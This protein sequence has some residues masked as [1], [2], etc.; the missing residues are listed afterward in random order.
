M[1]ACVACLRKKLMRRFQQG[2]Y[3]RLPARLLHLAV[4]EAEALA[5]TTPEP[6]LFF[7]AL[8]EEKVESLF[9]WAQRQSRFM[10]NKVWPANVSEKPHRGAKGPFESVQ[11]LGPVPFP[12]NLGR[13]C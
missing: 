2:P 4:T 5:W 7:P 6:L 3:R 1:A 11:R 13:F 9:R 12:G 8:A 10:L